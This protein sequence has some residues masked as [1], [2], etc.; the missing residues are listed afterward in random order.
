MARFL[1]TCNTRNMAESLTTPARREEAS[2]E[3]C[4]QAP[5]LEQYLR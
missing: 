2:E 1:C 3:A 5:P 4:A